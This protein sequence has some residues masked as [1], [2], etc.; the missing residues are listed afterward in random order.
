MPSHV[1]RAAAP[2]P[3]PAPQHVPGGGRKRCTSNWDNSG[4][5]NVKKATGRQQRLQLCCEDRYT[6]HETI[7][8]CATRYYDIVQGLREGARG[9]T[10]QGSGGRGGPGR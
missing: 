2:H 9:T 8:F 1:I 6:L 3:I 7:T 4:D 10:A 5:D